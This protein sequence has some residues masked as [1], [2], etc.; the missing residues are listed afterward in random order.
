MRALAT[1]YLDWLLGT[2]YSSLAP[3]IIPFEPSLCQAE[4]FT[5]WKKNVTNSEKV[6]RY[7]TLF[8]I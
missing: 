2:D 8:Q 7:R 4:L 1:G 6:S 5:I 3:L